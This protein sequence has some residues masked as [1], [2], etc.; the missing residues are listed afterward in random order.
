MSEDRTFMHLDAL[1]QDCRDEIKRRIEQRDRYSV[2]MTVALSA[3]VAV[4]FASGNLGRAI[5]A[6]PLASI[7]FTV[8]I[9][10]SYRIHRLITEYLRDEIEPALAALARVSVGKEWE[11]WYLHPGKHKEPQVPGVRRWFFLLTMWVV[12]FLSCL[13]F[14]SIES[15]SVLW[16][17]AGFYGLFC[18]VVTMW[19]I[20][21]L[22][23]AWS[24]VA[25]KRK[26]GQTQ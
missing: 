15:S 25:S 17:A 18:V 24:I 4:S 20:G 23:K 22:N 26:R 14:W 13:Y 21:W 3:I 16:F 12:S 1:R 2:Q 5:I 8:L 7:Y 10:Y 6:A 9:L 19:D 11:T